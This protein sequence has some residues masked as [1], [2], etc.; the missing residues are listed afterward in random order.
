[1]LEGYFLAVCLAGCPAHFPSS[2]F[3]PLFPPRCPP[4]GLDKLAWGR[5][6]HFVTLFPGHCFPLNFSVKAL[7]KRKSGKMCME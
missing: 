1:M 7:L 4:R 6:A 2:V 5:S 3:F